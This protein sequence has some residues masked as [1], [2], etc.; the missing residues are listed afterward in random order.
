MMEEKRK[1]R[2]TLLD[3]TDVAEAFL[4][5]G[6]GFPSLRAEPGAD[7]REEPDPGRE[8]GPDPRREAP[9][10]GREAPDPGR[11]APDPGHDPAPARPG[12]GGFEPPSPP[13]PGR[14]LLGGVRC[15][16][17]T[18]DDTKFYQVAPRDS[19]L[20]SFLLIYS[21]ERAAGWPL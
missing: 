14:E 17:E 12:D 16:K 5:E 7:P 18:S 4:E 11:E 8:E 15:V 9:D 3:L 19:K 21:P 20:L 10:P 13:D 6:G 1:T 2:L